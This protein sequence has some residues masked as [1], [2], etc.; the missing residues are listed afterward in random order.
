MRSVHGKLVSAE[1]VNDMPFVEHLSSEEF[2]ELLEQLPDG[3]LIVNERGEI[4]YVNRRLES[5]LGYS[6]SELFGASV[7]ELIP[8][9]VR[10]RHADLRD[11]FVR[12]PTIRPMGSGRELVAQCKDGQLLAV[13]VSL[14]PFG[15]GTS[16]DVMAIVR[17]VTVQRKVAEERRQNADLFRALFD[18]AP[19]AMAL[20]TLASSGQQTVLRANESLA[21]LVGVPLDE[22]RGIALTRF[23]HPDEQAADKRLADEMILEGKPLVRERRYLKADGSAIWGELH[24]VAIVDEAGT[25]SRMVA[26]I[27]DITDRKR[28]QLTK[29]RQSRLWESLATFSTSL[30]GDRFADVLGELAERIRELFS[31][32]ASFVVAAPVEP[33]VVDVR[34][35]SG[36]IRVVTEI[37]GGI[38]KPSMPLLEWTSKVAASGDAMRVSSIG[39]DAEWFGTSD[40]V[41]RGPGLLAPVH[42]GDGS[43]VVVVVRSVDGDPFDDEERE[44]LSRFVKQAQ[45]VIEVSD[46]RRHERRVAILEDRHRIA[47]DLH[48]RVVGRLFATGIRLQGLMSIGESTIYDE[49]NRAVEEIDLAITDL[50]QS[51]FSLIHADEQIGI[52]GVRNLLRRTLMEKQG[53]GFDLDFVA[54]GPEI[55][56]SR[57]AVDHLVAVVSE[58]VVNAHR[59]A[60]CGRVKVELNNDSKTVL[61][62][63]TDDGRGFTPGYSSGNG[64][65][66]LLGRAQELGGTFEVSTSPNQGT[67]VA[68]RIPV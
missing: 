16:A 59:H 46:R 14:S 53:L 67:S 11:A 6:R 8:A 58:S 20:T 28:S 56:L 27:V 17:D 50:R 61:L 35:V 4:Q 47:R 10:S 3:L 12:S 30:F 60:Q 68:W 1:V 43:F 32:D 31:A 33:G 36:A 63:V 25:V 37:R 38:R 51:I 23:T 39:L 7:D 66:S 42:D 52:E 29:E 48:D 26:H 18:Q 62:R 19:V 41:A 40:L 22:M 21:S 9:S 65:S 44:L 55:A 13:E 64:L 2:V 54:D 49:A 45:L 24:A 15:R 57:V 34:S 5:M